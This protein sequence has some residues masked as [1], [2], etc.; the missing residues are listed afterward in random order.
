MILLGANAEV[1][2]EFTDWLRRGREQK[3]YLIGYANGDLGY[4]EEALL[5]G[6]SRAVREATVVAPKLGFHDRTDAEQAHE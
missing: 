2:S 5:E 3:V 1:F 6:L 4:L